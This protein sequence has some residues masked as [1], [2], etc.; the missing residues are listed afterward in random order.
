M[1][2]E[3]RVFIERNYFLTRHGCITCGGWT[4]KQGAHPMLKSDDDDRQFLCDGCLASGETGIRE[5]L[6]EHAKR[7]EEYATDLRKGASEPWE[8]PSILQ[9]RW[10]RA[11]ADRPDCNDQPKRLYKND[12]IVTESDVAVAEKEQNEAW[13]RAG[14]SLPGEATIGDDEKFPFDDDENPF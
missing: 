9:L 12:V 7:L 10:Y 13:A 4:E 5:R 1:S 6:L 3:N 14:V 2:N 11:K 8:M